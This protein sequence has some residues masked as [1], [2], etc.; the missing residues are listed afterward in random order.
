MKFQESH[1]NE[2]NILFDIALDLYKD[3][4][5][6]R[7]DIVN[8]SRKQPLPVLRRLIANVLY[9]TYKDDYILDE[10]SEVINRKRATFIHH[11]KTHINDCSL[12]KN[13][14]QKYESIKREF[15]KQIEKK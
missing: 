13:Y 6:K 4:G 9:D 15:L 8:T 11:R 10:L 14:K 7:E 1:K 12:Y 3:C 2:I 5:F